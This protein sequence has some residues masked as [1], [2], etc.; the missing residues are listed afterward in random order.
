MGWLCSGQYLPGRGTASSLKRKWAGGRRGS[1]CFPAGPEKCHGMEDGFITPRF[2]LTSSLRGRKWVPCRGTFCAAR[3]NDDSPCRR[4]GG[5]TF[6]M[7]NIPSPWR[8]L[9]LQFLPLFSRAQGARPGG[10]AFL[11]RPNGWARLKPHPRNHGL[12]FGNCR[13]RVRR[14][15]RRGGGGRWR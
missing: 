7:G 9:R 4:H 1:R 6:H 3:Q 8:S 5:Q 14:A 13:F 11:P 10:A 15:G 12:K 2:L